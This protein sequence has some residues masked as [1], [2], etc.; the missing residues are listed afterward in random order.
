[1]IPRVPGETPRDLSQPLEEIR[2]QIDA[3]HDGQRLDKALTA[4]LPWRSRTSV[5]RLIDDGRVGLCGEREGERARPSARVRAGDIVR[6]EIPPQPDP[7]PLVPLGEDI[8][9]L[10]E[11]RWMIAVDKPAGMAV[12][13]AGR[14]V[15]GTLIHFLHARYRHDDPAHDVVPRLLHRIDRETS[16]VIATGL[17]EHFHNRVARQFEDREVQKTYLAVVH[18]RPE[19][20]EGVIEFG[21]GPDRRSPVRLK[22]EARRDGSGLPSRT[23]YR[24]VG[25]NG[26]FSLVELVPKTGRTHQLRVHMSALGHPLVGDKIYGP[27]E[28]IFLEHLE[29]RLSETSRARLILER[30]ALHAHRLRFHHPF[31]ERELELEAPLPADMAALV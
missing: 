25:G 29:G 4:Y 21:I 7:Q 16:G 18:G 2:I 12:H 1:M 24:V 30:Q 5:V 23:N 31:L 19:P 28:Q 10:H 11:D 15:G 6:I 22:L 20:A 13:P 26:E 8:R 17:D 3:R 14:T 9:I 27:D